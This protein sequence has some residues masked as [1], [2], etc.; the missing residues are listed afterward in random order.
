MTD[1]TNKSMRGKA[2]RRFGKMPE[3][4]AMTKISD[5]SPEEVAERHRAALAEQRERVAT[6]REELIAN[7]R[8]VLQ[9]EA[10]LAAAMADEALL[11]RLVE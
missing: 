10:E 7:K 8:R 1:K 11:G 3:D 5:F 2:P 9:L 4:E 6:L